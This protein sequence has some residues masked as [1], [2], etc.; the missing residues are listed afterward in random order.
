MF[1]T[2]TTPIHVI[3]FNYSNFSNY[4]WCQCRVW[5]TCLCFC[6]IVTRQFRLKVCLLAI[7]QDQYDTNTRSWLYLTIPFSQFLIVVDVSDSDS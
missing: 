2:D 6:F 1:G 3:I 5:G 4:Y 7:D